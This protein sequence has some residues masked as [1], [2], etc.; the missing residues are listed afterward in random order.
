MYDELKR[1]CWTENLKLPGLGLVLYTFGNVSVADRSKGVFAIKPSGVDYDRMKPEDIVVVSLETGA[2]ADGT[3][4]PSSDTNTHFELYRAF[5]GIGGIVHTHST[6]ATAWAQAARAV[7]LY[8][9]THA[10]HLTEDIPCT[11]FMEAS[12]IVNNYETETGLQIIEHFRKNRLDPEEIKM[13]L[14]AGHGPFTWGRD[15]AEAVR[16][17]KVL[18][19]LCHMAQLT[20]AIRPDTPRLC[21]HLIRKHYLRKHGKDATYGQKTT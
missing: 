3:L 1:L 18:E 8:G 6:Y 15:G 7:P 5:P 10:D 16:N 13:V 2:V 21:E 11:D 9:T 17:A 14:V 4:R 19:E 20:E 12:R